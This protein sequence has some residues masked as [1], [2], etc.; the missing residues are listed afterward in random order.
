MSTGVLVGSVLVVVLVALLITIQRRRQA[1]E[2]MKLIDSW[3][4]FGD[5][6]SESS[7]EADE[8]PEDTAEELDWNNV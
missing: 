6:I 5:G 8:S 3:G 7:E 2:E 4:V 1:A